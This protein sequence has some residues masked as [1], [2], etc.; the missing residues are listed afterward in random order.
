M[1]LAIFHLNEKLAEARAMLGQIGE[2][3]QS[4]SPEINRRATRPVRAEIAELERA[5]LALEPLSDEGLAAAPAD[6]E[7][8]RY[9]LAYRG[10]H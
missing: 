4:H 1:R 10:A 7:G 6:T 3:L 2:E 9:V 5:I 8:Y